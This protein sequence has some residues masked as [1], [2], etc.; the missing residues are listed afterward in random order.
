VNLSVALAIALLSVAITT[1]ATGAAG[2]GGQPPDVRAQL[3]RNKK[4]M[5]EVSAQ[6]SKVTFDRK[7][8]EKYLAEWL[9][10]DE[11]DESEGSDEDEKDGPE[12]VDLAAALAEP[13]YVAWA[14]ERKLDPK[15]WLLKSMRITLTHAKRHAPAQAAEMKAQM[16]AQR[17]ELAKHC[18][19]M[20]PNA[21]RDMDKAF[22]GA[23]EMVRET[24]AMMALFPEPTRAEA[25]LLSEYDDRLQEVIEGG[26]RGRDGEGGPDGDAGD[27]PADEDEEE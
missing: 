17:R 23:D 3:E 6:A 1:G 26:R 13:K 21:C 16:D 8:V 4:C 9:S 18:E 22:A 27:S 7:D 20:G 24:S 12:C 10:F 25:A 5:R 11:L 19:S 14:R 15:S 2:T